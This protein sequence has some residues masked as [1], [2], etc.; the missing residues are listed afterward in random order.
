MLILISAVI[1]VEPEMTYSFYF[2]IIQVRH[3]GQYNACCLIYY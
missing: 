1:I 2:E 3:L